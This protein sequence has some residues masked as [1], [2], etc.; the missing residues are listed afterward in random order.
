[1]IIYNSTIVSRDYASCVVI[2][3]LNRICNEYA[4]QTMFYQSQAFLTEKKNRSQ[5]LSGFFDNQ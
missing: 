1:M 2:D 4:A 5:I 3:F